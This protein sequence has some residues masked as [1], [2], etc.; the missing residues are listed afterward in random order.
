MK[1]SET[2][3]IGKKRLKKI[4]FSAWSVQREERISDCIAARTG[5]LEA[6]QIWSELRDSYKQLDGPDG[7][8]I[9]FSPIVLD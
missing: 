9:V 3:I 2:V 8:V 7:F 5:I 6:E 4:H 1:K